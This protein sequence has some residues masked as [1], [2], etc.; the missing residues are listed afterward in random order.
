MLLLGSQSVGRKTILNN[1]Q[2]VYD[3]LPVD[4]GEYHIK[5]RVTRKETETL[6]I[7]N[8]Q[9]KMDSLLEKDQSLDYK[10]LITA[11]TIVWFDNKIYG[12]ALNKK[13]A[14]SFLEKFSGKTHLCISGATLVIRENES[15][16]IRRDFYDSTEVTM[17]S[18][19][20]LINLYLNHDE[21]IG[22]AGAYAI[23][24]LGYILVEHIKGNVQNII[25]LPLNKALN[26]FT[27]Q[28]IF[29]LL[30]FK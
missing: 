4:V 26:H 29:S 27:E 12:K 15:T 1:A 18:N 11:D 23:Q 9:L 20:Q 10:I 3:S 17:T 28:G 13:E 6:V 16:I 22:K 25:G 24:G 21:W 19:K 30:E 8:S 5:G 2:L 14:R 7:K